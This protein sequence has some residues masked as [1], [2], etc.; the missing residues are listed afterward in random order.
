MTIDTSKQSQLTSQ[1]QHSI[2]YVRPYVA[3]LVELLPQPPCFSDLLLDQ[4]MTTLTKGREEYQLLPFFY[5]HLTSKDDIAFRHEVWRDLD[6]NSVATG[7][8]SFTNEMHVVRQRLSWAQKTRFTQHQRAIHLDAVSHYCN[9]VEHLSTTLCTNDVASRALLEFRKIVTNYTTSRE[10]ESL[11]RES[12]LLQTKLSEIRYGINVHGTHVRVLR[13]DGEAD[14]GAEIEEAF[15]RFQQGSVTDYRLKF[16]DWPDMNHVEAQVADR[17]A[18]LFREVFSQLQSFCERTR[19]FID[20]DLG[21][22]DR[23]IQFYFAYL[24]FIGPLKANG[25]PFCLP[26]VH[27]TKAIFARETFDIALASKL[28]IQKAPVVRNDFSLDTVERIIVISGP[29][30]G[31]K[32]TFSRTF[33]QIHFL[34]SLGCP[35][36]GEQASLFLF[37]DLYTHFGKEEDS[38]FESGKLEDDLLRIQKVLQRATS[39]SIIIMNEIFASTT[40]QDALALGTKVLKKVIALDALCVVVTFIDEL[41]LLDPS[42]VSMTSSVNPDNPVERTFKIVRN[43][44]DGL[45]YA[46]S[47]AEKYG[48]TYDRLRKRI[49]P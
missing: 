16:S 15:E 44:A 30:Q 39:R 28:A 38:T 31:G 46:M 12:Q 21:T 29:N 19:A 35:V 22:F 48:L 45:A 47:I 20:D 11:V 26:K 32:T 49:S 5:E 14:Y 33:G 25:L 43:P 13:Y 36:P 42:I 40:T 24:D 7:L 41:T 1:V 37:D 4:V 17:V 23:E 27:D 2:L 34:A 18:L 10:F 8:R 6:I 3:E 9:A